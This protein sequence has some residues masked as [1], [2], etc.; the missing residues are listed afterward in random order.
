MYIEHPHG[1]NCSQLPQVFSKF[2]LKLNPVLVSLSLVFLWCW[3]HY[4]TK[5]TS[6]DDDDDDNGVADVGTVSK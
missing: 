4:Y 5:W 1:S 6:H 3:F 2:T